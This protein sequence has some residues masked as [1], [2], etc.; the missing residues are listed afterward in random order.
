ML[1]LGI[2]YYENKVARVLSLKNLGDIF[3]IQIETKTSKSI[4]ATR[5]GCRD[6]KV[7][8]WSNGE[9]TKQSGSS[10]CIRHIQTSDRPQTAG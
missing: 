5:E 1:F 10:S 7:P 9:E 4:K 3:F 8:I 2:L 6:E